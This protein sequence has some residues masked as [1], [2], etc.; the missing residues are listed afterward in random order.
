MSRK[1][2]RYPTSFAERNK[3]VIA[4][5][6]MLAAALVFLVTFNAQAL[7][8]IGGGDVE[9]AH[10]AEGGGLKEGNE[11]R[12]AGVKV[13]EVTDIS[14]EGATVVVKFRI[15]GVELGNETTAA[16]KVKTMLGQKYLALSPAGRETLDGA[17]PV[18]N[19]T[20]PYD[21][22]AAFSD[23]S[24]TID[25]IDTEK[26]E[27]SFTTLA[28]AFEDTPESVQGMVK[29]L[30]ALSRTISSRDEELA[31]LFASTTSVTGTLEQRNAEFEKIFDDGSALLDELA[32]RRKAVKAMLDGTAALGTQLKG[33]VADNEKQLRPALAELDK[34][35]E[36]LQ[37]NQ[38]NLTAALQKI[39]PYYRM[40]ATAMGNGRWVDSYLCGLFD[41]QQHPVLE[42]DVVRDCDPN[43]GG[44]K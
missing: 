15:K 29:G 28:D 23:L 19:T 22:N 30:T 21:V 4:I 42:N 41:D 31:Q 27:E 17:I 10:F 20:T 43:A 13:G 12:V 24:D 37:R 32:A 25:T 36:I 1:V 5:V 9:E 38:D 35:T 8:V 14:L 18:E 40:I 7:P 33:L 34:V 16:V 11:V 26:L 3:V 2:R 44:A 6:G 39:G